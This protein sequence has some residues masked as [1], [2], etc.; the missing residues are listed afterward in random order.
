MLSEE[1]GVAA[2]LLRE[3]ADYGVELTHAQADALAS[4]HAILNRWN[5]RLHLVAPTTDA[6]FA[7]R[8]ILESLFA[9]RLIEPNSHIVDVGSGGGLP[10]VPLLIT[11]PDVRATL[12]EANTKKAVFLREGLIEAG[13]AGRAEIIINRFEDQSAPP[14]ADTL[15]CRAL[16]RFAHFLPQLLAWSTNIKLLLLF[17]GGELRALIRDESFDITAHR[18]PQSERRFIFAV[19]RRNAPLNG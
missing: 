13:C 1:T 12:I 3:A 10:I 17:G 7:R 6:N 4:Y 5:P 9:S 2:T 16:D 19:R 18:I 8:H 14:R 11:R 15:T